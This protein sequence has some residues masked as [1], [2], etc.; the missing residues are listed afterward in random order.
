MALVDKIIQ[1]AKEY[2]N[3][4]N[5]NLNS[6][7]YS[8]DYCYNTFCIARDM[9]SQD[10]DYLSMHLAFYLASWGMYRGSSSL[11][12]YNYKIHIPAVRIIMKKEYNF[13]LGLEYTKLSQKD[14]E[15]TKKEIEKIKKELTD[16]YK[17]Q[18]A[19][20]TGTLV[21]KI[22]LGTL[23][24]T[25]AYD[26]LFCNVVNKN[27]QVIFGE[28][29]PNIRTERWNIDSLFDLVHFYTSNQD[30]FEKARKG[31]IVFGRCYPQMKL[32][33]MGLWQIGFQDSQK[34][35]KKGNNARLQST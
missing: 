20:P 1:S 4:M 26:T 25:P 2:Y 6:R 17:K 27:K 18:N 16:C 34:K 15:K 12:Q 3:I 31:F 5:R 7:F 28:N 32:L 9:D 33:D 22:L 23:G 35:N 10:Y 8:W 30:N 24:C 29:Y 19:R 21:T 13:L 11:I 14:K